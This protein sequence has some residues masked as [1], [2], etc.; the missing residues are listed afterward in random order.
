MIE[1]ML[2]KDPVLA[3]TLSPE[4]IVLIDCCLLGYKGHQFEGVCW[5]TYDSKLYNHIDHRLLTEHHNHMANMMELIMLPNVW[6]IEEVA[7]EF[8]GAIKHLGRNI[9][10]LSGHKRPPKHKR[11]KR[12][13][14]V[15]KQRDALSN[16]HDLFYEVYKVLKSKSIDR[17]KEIPFDKNKIGVLFDMVKLLESEMNLK[18]DSDYI[19][20]RRDEDRSHLS[21]TDEKLVAC[22]YYLSIYGD[23]KP[24]LLTADHDLQRLL[25]KISPLIGSYSFFPDN[26][27]FRRQLRANNFRL[28]MEI[29]GVYELKLDSA[30]DIRFDNDFMLPGLSR[31]ECDKLKIN[32]SGLWRNFNSF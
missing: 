6:S 17:N 26:G 9:R 11:F 1:D 2:S 32:V 30:S 21:S 18:V 8:Y 29:N 24:V 5:E 12:E 14:G 28:Y 4:N 20:G 3:E 13:Y 7:N 27:V 19:K 15:E 23:K 10:Y 16:V 31:K 22:L 25:G